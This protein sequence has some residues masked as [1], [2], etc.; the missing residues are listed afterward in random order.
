[1]TA[2]SPEASVRTVIPTVWV[3]LDSLQS[4]TPSLHAL[5]CKWEKLHSDSYKYAVKSKCN[6]DHTH[7][8]FIPQI[9]F[10]LTQ[11]SF[12]YFLFKSFPQI[13]GGIMNK[14]IHLRH[15]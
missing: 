14:N 8:H 12:S 2:F 5:I 4:T 11:N 15:G 6:L 3:G 9:S 10:V 1:M 7:Q 13:F